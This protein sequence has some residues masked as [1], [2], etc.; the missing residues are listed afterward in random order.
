MKNE[1]EKKIDGHV[2]S[3]PA[4]PPG[5]QDSSSHR[6]TASHPPTQR[7]RNGSYEPH[8]DGFAAGDDEPPATAGAPQPDT[9][10]AGCATSVATAAEGVATSVTASALL[11][12]SASA[13]GMAHEP[14]A[15]STTFSRMM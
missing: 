12:S 4:C 5:R 8:P 3:S 13:V 2:C 10:T 11:A 15:Y 6:P 14:R 9:A 7:L 1:E